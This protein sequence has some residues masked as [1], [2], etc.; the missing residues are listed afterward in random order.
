MSLYLF[1]LSIS[2]NDDIFFRINDP[3]A[4]DVNQ[5][6]VVIENGDSRKLE[7]LGCNADRGYICH[8]GKYRSICF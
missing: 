5:C 6:A 8:Q 3:S 4:H 1:F 2:A 7:S